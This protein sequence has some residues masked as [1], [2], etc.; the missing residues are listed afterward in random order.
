MT[1]RPF[2]H[3]ISV[4]MCTR[5]G[6]C[7]IAEQLES[8]ITQACRPSQVI[9]FDDRSQ[10]DTI[11][12]INSIAT[13][14]P[15]PVRVVVN[16][17]VQGVI[18]NFERAIAACEH[19][20][21]VLADQDDIWEPHKLATIEDLFAACSNT[22]AIFSDASIIDE[23]GRP[24]GRG[25]WQAQGLGR[26]ARRRL[27]EGR[28]LSQLLRWNVVTGATL[29]FRSELVPS[30]LPIPSVTM[31]D[32]WIALVA[33]VLGEVVAIEE[34]LV[35]YRVH[36]SNAVGLPPSNPLNL[37]NKRATDDNQRLAEL[38]LFEAAV[39][40]TRERAGSEAILALQAK[41]GFLTTRCNLPATV[42]QRSTP[43]VRSLADGSY[44]RLAHGMRSATHDLVFGR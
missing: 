43:V 1:S 21:I 8:L 18:R 17:R 40:R 29:A 26:R 39:A 19:Q 20:I 37:V 13:S 6:G 5:N 9:I 25:L 31:H 38:A 42:W 16:D 30:I 27:C 11:A 10:D 3:G 33:A 15:F 35:R 2:R 7:H 44:H 24:T 36:G 41:T 12:K 34:R 28:V 22:A 23:N 4:A 32:Y 14:A